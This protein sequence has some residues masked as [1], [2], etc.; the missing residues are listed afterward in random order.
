MKKILILGASGSI[1]SQTCQVLKKTS[2]Q[3]RLVAISVGDRIVK[4]PPILQ[5]FPYVRFICVKN[6]AD[7]DQLKRKFPKVS[8][9]SGDEGLLE[10]IRTVKPDLVINALVGFV[11]LAPTLETIKLDIDLALANKESLVAGGDL[12][13]KAL[14]KSKS[15][16]F[17][18]DSEHVAITKCLKGIKPEEVKRIVLTCSGGPFLSKKISKL[19]KVKA[20]DA[21]KHPTWEMGNKITIDSATLMNKVFEEV[22]AYYLFKPWTSN[23]SVVF[24]PQSIIHSLVQFV[25]GTYSA[26]IGD[27]DMK[28]AILYALGENTHNETGS[29]F[30]IEDCCDLTFIRPDN[31]R[32]QILNIGKDIIAKRG[33]LGTIAVTADDILVDAFLNGKI[34]F[35]DIIDIIK[36]C[37]SNI[38][39]VKNPSY[40]SLLECRKDTIA[41]VNSLINTGDKK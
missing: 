27:H 35:L 2:L 16:I 29:I 4:I 20:K 17:P 11:G 34:G 24:H 7:V 23:I 6:P 8:F 31:E 12:I 32:T 14:S 21:L 10:I 5:D 3:Y 28:N 38:P 18:I 13:D 9:F 22:E 41:Y 25:D 39:Y 1:G 30:A 19:A 33:N 40:S 26:D 37:L 36:K 15:R